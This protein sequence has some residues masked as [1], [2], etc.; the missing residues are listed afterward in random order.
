MKADLP[1]NLTTNE[2]TLEIILEAITK[3]GYK[4]G[5]EISIALDVAASELYNKEKG[6]LR[7]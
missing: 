6:L 5:S 3:A 1:P 7:I 2:E 4:P